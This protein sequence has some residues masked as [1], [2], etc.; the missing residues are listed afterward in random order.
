MGVLSNSTFLLG[1]WKIFGSSM[2]HHQEWADT[3]GILRVHRENC[4]YME[5]ITNPVLFPW[6]N[7]FFDPFFFI[8][9][10]PH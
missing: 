4:T 6:G 1:W 3:F 7:Y 5:T 2:I 8:Q 9:N 10:T